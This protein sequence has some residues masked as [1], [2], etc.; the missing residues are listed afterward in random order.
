MGVAGFA[1]RKAFMRELQNF[2]GAPTIMPAMPP[3]RC[4]TAWQVK[5]SVKGRDA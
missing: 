1:I 5:E 3:K 2:I 4:Q